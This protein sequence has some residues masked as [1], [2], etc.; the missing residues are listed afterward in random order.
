MQENS[1]IDY[2]KTVL[3]DSFKDFLYQNT[4]DI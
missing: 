2:Q 3:N 1:D 4:Y